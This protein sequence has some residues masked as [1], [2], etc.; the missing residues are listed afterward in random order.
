VAALRTSVSFI[1]ENPH[2]VKIIVRCVLRLLET[3]PSL[4]TVCHRSSE[5]L[6]EGQDRQT[7]D[8]RNKAH[9]ASDGSKRCRAREKE[10]QESVKPTNTRD[11]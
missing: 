6:G 7:H 8:I 10:W 11:G 4:V 2:L 3:V 9:F 5:H 1:T